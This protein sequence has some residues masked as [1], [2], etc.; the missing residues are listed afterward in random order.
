MG[1]ATGTRA[2]TGRWGSP[3]GPHHGFGGLEGKPAADGVPHGGPVP[4]AP[5]PGTQPVAVTPLSEPGEH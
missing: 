1:S 2:G 4:G 3:K 5:P